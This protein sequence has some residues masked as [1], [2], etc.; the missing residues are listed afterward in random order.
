MYSKEQS[1][2][3]NTSD[4]KPLF[5]DGF[6]F[7]LGSGRGCGLS[8]WHSLGFSLTFFLN[9][10]IWNHIISTKIYDKRDDFDFDLLVFRFCMVLSKSYGVYVSSLIHFARASSYGSDFIDQNMNYELISK[11]NI[12]CW[13]ENS[14]IQFMLTRIFS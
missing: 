9:V 11:Y 3:A 2:N 5:L 10:S 13:F 8:L 7:L 1:N 4:T 14:S 12:S 6:L